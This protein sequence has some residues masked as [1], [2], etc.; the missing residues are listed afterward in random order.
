MEVSKLDFQTKVSVSGECEKHGH[1]EA[2]AL[3]MLADK[4]TC[5]RCNADAKAERDARDAEEKRLIAERVRAERLESIGVGPRHLGKR[6]DSFVAETQE[7][8]KALETCRALADGVCNRKQRLP[9]LILCGNPGTGKTHLTCAMVQQC[10]D[11][12]LKVLKPNMMDIIRAIKASWKKGAEQ[13][14]EEVINRFSYCDLLIIDEIGVQFGT[15]TE[16]MYVFEIINR[17]YEACLPTVLVSNLDIDA[18]K[19]EVGIRVIDRLREDG[20]KLLAFTG[21][22]WRKA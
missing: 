18:L 9:S 15:D 13:D 12:G 11:S 5:P 10:F 17:R 3:S 22:S 7:Q 19:K 21:E 14:E 8:A 4:V 6:F 2:E 16:R 20:G 1:W